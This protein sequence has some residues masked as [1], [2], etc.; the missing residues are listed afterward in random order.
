MST[1]R[2]RSTASIKECPLSQSFLEMAQDLVL[3]QIQSHKLS[4]EEMH[5]VLQQTYT[6]LQALKMQEDSQSSVAVATPETPSKPV[7]W[8]KSIT[9]HTVTCPGVWS[10]L[11]ATVGQTS[12]GPWLGWTVLPRQV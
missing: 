2:L 11:Q 6:S 9:K 8:K 5:P 10:Q 1:L 7:N 12:P 3:A 4:P